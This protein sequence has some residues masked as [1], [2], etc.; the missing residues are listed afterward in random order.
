MRIATISMHHVTKWSSIVDLWRLNGWDLWRISMDFLGDD[1]KIR[2]F[3]DG[4]VEIVRLGPV[5]LQWVF[6]RLK[7]W[8]EEGFYG[9]LVKVEWL[10][11]VG[12]QRDEVKQWWTCGDQ[13]IGTCGSKR[14][15]DEV[16]VVVME[17]EANLQGAW[18]D[19]RA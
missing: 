10:R 18:L 16:G 12:L 17:L 7:R 5:N 13:V 9:G 6:N 4:I 14:W 8:R 11:L 3:N 1:E 15:R 19:F 2:V